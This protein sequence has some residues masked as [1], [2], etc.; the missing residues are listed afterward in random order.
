MSAQDVIASRLMDC[1]APLPAMSAGRVAFVG[2]AAHPMTPFMGQGACQALEDAVTL[3]WLVNR[4]D[5]PHSLAA[6]SAA[7][8]PRTTKIMK[9]SARAGRLSLLRGR[10][11]IAVRDLALKIAG[12]RISDDRVAASFDGVFSWR[13][14]QSNARPPSDAAATGRPPV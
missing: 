14:P 9:R 2:D 5:V 6:Y 13:P 11:G 10:A 8:L 3:A 4:A 7:R 1:S 12:G